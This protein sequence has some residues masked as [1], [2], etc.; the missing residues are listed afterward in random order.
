MAQLPTHSACVGGAVNRL[1]PLVMMTALVDAPV[2]EA[3]NLG[4]SIA[5][6]DAGFAEID[7]D[8]DLD[9]YQTR[10]AAPSL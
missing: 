4:Y 2:A 7:N 10:W 9:L 3:V 8:G 5:T 6:R 1:I